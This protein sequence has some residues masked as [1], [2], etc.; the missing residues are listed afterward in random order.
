MRP[1][2]FTGTILV[3]A[4]AAWTAAESGAGIAR[5]QTPPLYSARAAFALAHAAAAANAPAQTRPSLRPPDPT[6]GTGTHTGGS[7]AVSLPTAVQHGDFHPQ[8]TGVGGRQTADV[9][10]GKPAPQ[11]AFPELESPAGEPATTAGEADPMGSSTEV[12]AGPV[13][14]Y[15]ALRD[16]AVKDDRPFVLWVNEKFP[17]VE[18]DLPD[19]CHYHEL[20]WQGSDVPRFILAVPDA[21]REDVWKVGEYPGRPESADWL[22]AEAADGR[23]RLESFLNPPPRPVTP[24]YHYYPTAPAYFGP[25]PSFGGFGG[26]GFFRGGFVGGCGGRG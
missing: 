23:R 20:S 4:V 25:P 6:G 7:A 11:S 8:S 21:R 12:G 3:T 9:P 5:G 14:A 26:G 22:K 19:W 13:D 18:R 24:E 17:A 2:R 16:R 15:R 10:P 1:T